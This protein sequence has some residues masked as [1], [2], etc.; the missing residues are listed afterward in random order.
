MV[1]EQPVPP[2]QIQKPPPDFLKLGLNQRL[3]PLLGRQ[4]TATPHY[5]SA[6]LATEA[7]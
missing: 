6:D 1:I 3:H 2:G 5:R 4:H 7:A